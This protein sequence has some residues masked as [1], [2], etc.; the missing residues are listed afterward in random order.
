MSR[1]VGNDELALVGREIAVGHVN[2]DALFALGFQAV[3]QQGVVNMIAGVAH[4]L[5][6]ALEGGQLVFI[7]FLLSNSS[8]PIRVDFPS[9]TEP[10]VRKRNRSFCSS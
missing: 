2:G 6:V 4:A 5:A 3:T 7:K 10:A 1:R 8:R 9:S